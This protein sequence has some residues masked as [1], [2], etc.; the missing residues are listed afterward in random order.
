MSKQIDRAKTVRYLYYEDLHFIPVEMKSDPMWAAQCLIFSKYNSRQLLDNDKAKKFRDIDDGKIDEKLYKKILDPILPDGSG[1]K[2]EYVVADWKANPIYLHINNIVEAN[3]EKIPMNMYC[4]AVDEFAMEKQ[5]K[6]NM[7]ILGRKQFVKYINDFNGQLGFPKLKPSEDPY[8]YARQMQQRLQGGNVAKA[9]SKDIPMGLMDSIK[10]AITDNEDLALFNEFVYK[11]DVEIAIELGIKHYMTA[12]KFPRIGERM[13]RDL[14]S[15]NKCAGRYYTSQTSGLPTL[16]RLDP[17]DVWTSPFSQAD[18]SDITAWFIEYDVTYSDFLRMF[19]ANRTPE[20]LRAIF[21]HNKRY[22]S[23]HGVDWDRSRTSERMAAKIRIGYHEWQSQDCEVHAE[24]EVR[25]NLSYRKKP[26]DWQPKKN[27]PSKKERISKNYNVWYKCYYLP[28]SIRSAGTLA[29]EDFEWQSQYIFDFGKLQ[30]QQRY[31]EDDRYSKS[32][33]VVWQ[34][35][36]MSFGEIMDRYMPKIHLLW[37]KYQNHITRTDVFKIYGDEL[38]EAMMELTDDAN[39][40]GKDSKLEWMR[41]LEQT[42]AGVSKFQ[43]EKGDPVDPVKV[44]T[45]G[46][47]RAATEILNQIQLLYQQMTVALGISD[48]REGIDPKPRTSLGGLQLAM[49]ASNNATYFI[50]KAYVDVYIEF[51]NRLMQYIIMVAKEGGQRLEQFKHIVGQANGMLLESIKDIPQHQ[52]GLHLENVNTD[53]Q[54]QYLRNLAEQ[55]VKAQMMDLEVLNLLVKVDNYKYA[56]VLMIMKYK[57]KVREKQQEQQMMHQQAMELKQMDLDIEMQKIKQRWDGEAMVVELGKQ[58]DMKI[59]QMEDRLKANTQM[60]MK[61]VIK[62]NRIEEHA[63]TTEID[64][65]KERV[66]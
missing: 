12:N 50:E 2:A 56:A 48:V 29:V 65:N 64:M 3:M 58:W 11:G 46:H 22:G 31:G 6:E 55:L 19:G 41:M 43:S 10:S 49:D 13:I 61:D 14:R 60:L 62:N 18:G 45:V 32:S 16:E 15:F 20:E 34:G 38:M 37:Q 57:Q 1:G 54:M 44:F 4:K 24:G 17:V 59:I 47:M 42:G 63:A 66:A 21:D 30:D 40:N 27:A 52:L 51:A 7:R 25:G 23:S 36:G 33:L 9:K 5:Q 8:T 28:M 53:Q 39:K 26:S 35:K